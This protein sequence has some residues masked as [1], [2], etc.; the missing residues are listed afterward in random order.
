MRLSQLSAGLLCALTASQATPVFET[1]HPGGILVV[2]QRAE[3]KTFNPVTALDGPSREVI[4]RMMADLISINRFSHACEPSLAESWSASKDGLHYTVTLRR[5]LRFSDGHPATAADIV[6]TFRVYLDEKIGSPQRELLVVGGKPVQAVQLDDRRVRFDFAA[7]YAAAERLFDG[8]AILPRHLLET[9]YN[10]GRFAQMWSLG[11]SPDSIA[12][13]GPFRLKQYKPGERVVLERNPYYWKSDPA[14]NRL[15]YLDEIQFIFV[16]TEEAQILRFVS[17]ETGILNRF[18]ARSLPLL[19]GK[20]VADIGP[21]LEYSFLFFNLG[22]NGKPWFAKT[23]FRQAVSAAIDRES[24][25]KLV[26]SGRATPLWTH[27]PP[28]NKAWINTALPHPPRSLARAKD[29]LSRAGFR[30]SAAGTLLDASAAPV[31]FTIVTSS[32]NPERER[33]AAIIQ[34]DLKQ[35]GI[36]VQVVPLEL[37]SLIDR[38]TATRQYD[39]AILALGGGDADPNAEMNVWLSSGAT[40]LWNPAQKSPATAW[41]REIDQLMRDQMI[42]IDPVRRK[43]LFDRV[44]A[45]EAEQSPIIALASPHVIVAARRDL[46]NFRPAILDHYT[47]WNAEFLFFRDG[48]KP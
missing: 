44:Q 16:P 37:R 41:E 34:D 48:P 29:L 17:G 40:H 13:L 12:G 5:G 25:V 15:P 19:G 7:P 21:S 18:S 6:F 11:A 42:E 22:P 1:G 35:L 2:A 45:I 28:G 26:Y 27:V 47:L 8:I 38:V 31:E 43:R 46:G 4:R 33:M 3:P 32:G 30:W 36:K 24:I 14:G 23:E 10:E 9:A 39:A 20:P